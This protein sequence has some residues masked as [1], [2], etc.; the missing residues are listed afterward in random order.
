[1]VMVMAGFEDSGSGHK[2][3][4]PGASRSWKEN[5]GTHTSRAYRKMELC[6]HWNFSPVTM[7]FNF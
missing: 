1:M 7:I 4:D 6:Q 3:K 5:Q 2:S